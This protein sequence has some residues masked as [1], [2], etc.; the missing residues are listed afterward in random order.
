MLK[1]HVKN[2]GAI[3]VLCLQGK[4]VFGETSALPTIVDS[5]PEVSMVVLDLNRVSTID[6]RGLGALLELRE[7]T[8]SKGIELRL[9][10]VTKLVNQVLEITHLNTVFEVTSEAAVMATA[11]LKLPTAFGLCAGSL[12]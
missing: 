6:A 11:S 5:Q 12:S 2:L 4:L 8:Q 10:N 3:S 7:K 1:I 9:T